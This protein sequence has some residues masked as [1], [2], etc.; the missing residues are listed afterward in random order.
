MYN[1]CIPACKKAV[2]TLTIKAKDF[3]TELTSHNVIEKDLSGE[4]RISGTQTPEVLKT[5]GVSDTPALNGT[6]PP[7]ALA[8]PDSQFIEINGLNV[9]VK[10]MG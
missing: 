9:H 4:S 7:Q 2:L 10:T 1:L 6:R 5:S 3:A 8:D